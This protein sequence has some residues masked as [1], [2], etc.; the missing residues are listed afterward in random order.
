MEE[1]RCCFATA[2]VTTVIFET[3]ACPVSG[4]T[5]GPLEND[6]VVNGLTVEPVGLVY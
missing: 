5:C 3:Q 1:V 6:I 4:C 2:R